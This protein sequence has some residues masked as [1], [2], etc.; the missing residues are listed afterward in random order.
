MPI[1]LESGRFL[2][3][4]IHNK[5]II[6]SLLQ[7]METYYLPELLL[8]IFFYYIPLFHELIIPTV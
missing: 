8:H 4:F 2:L 1:A 6:F 3:L 7:I 5:H